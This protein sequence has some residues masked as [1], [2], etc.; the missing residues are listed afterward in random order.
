MMTTNEIDVLLRSFL[1][2][3]EI[4]KELVEQILAVW[5]EAWDQGYLDGFDKG[6][7]TGYD[8][9]GKISHD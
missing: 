7:D 1:G 4:P 5:E 2:E 8:D 3:I 9:A 6:Y